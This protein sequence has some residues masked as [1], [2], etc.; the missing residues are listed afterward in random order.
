MKT[1]IVTA[2]LALSL[3]FGL[4]IPQAQA[5]HGGGHGDKMEK[6]FK[7]LK[8]TPEQKEKLKAHHEKQHETMKALREKR[9]AAREKVEQAFNTGTASN[10]TLRALHKEVQVA[11]NAVSDSRCE[12]KLA[13]RDILTP[14]Q[15]AKFDKMHGKHHGRGMGHHGDHDDDG[16]DD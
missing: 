6:M 14:E 15:R 12:G 3:C 2:A 9:K 11:S 7:E 8:L 4:C 13:V 10:D 5:R 1:S 16:D